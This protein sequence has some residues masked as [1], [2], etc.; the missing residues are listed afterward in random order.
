MAPT[1]LLAL[2]QKQ[3]E[4]AGKERREGRENGKEESEVKVQDNAVKGTIIG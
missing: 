4:Q 2:T 1:Y 3:K